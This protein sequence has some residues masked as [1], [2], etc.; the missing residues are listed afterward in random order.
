MVRT[1]PDLFINVARPTHQ[2]QVGQADFQQSAQSRDAL[3]GAAKNAES[4]QK[5]GRQHIGLRRVLQSVVI[6]VVAPGDSF[7]GSLVA[8]R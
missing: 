5:V 4:A 1:L 8:G 2:H 3:V 7:N 6:E